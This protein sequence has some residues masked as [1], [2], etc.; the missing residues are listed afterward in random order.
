MK[1]FK[2]LTFLLLVLGMSLSPLA[3]NEVKAATDYTLVLAATKTSVNASD[4]FN[5]T[6]TVE[7]TGTD[8]ISNFEVRVPFIRTIQDTT[9]GGETPSFNKVLAAT[10][11]PENFNSRAWLINT[12]DPKEKATYTLKYNVAASP[13]TPNGLISNVTLPASWKDPNGLDSGKLNSL[14]TFRADVYLN[15]K[16]DQSFEIPLPTLAALN[17]PISLVT[18]NSKYIFSGS[19]TTD[20]KTVTTANIKAFPNFTLESQDIK[21]EWLE[22]IDLSAATVASQLTNLDTNLAT[23]WGKITFNEANLP[24]LNKKVRVTFKNSDFVFA[25]KINVNKDI[26]SLTDA[27]ATFTPGTKIIVLELDK[28]KNLAIAPEIQTEESVIESDQESIE[29]KG[30]VSDPRTNVTYKIGEEEIKT[31]SGI[32]I[33]TGEFSFKV[34]LKEGS[35]DVE[36]STKY[37]NEE[38]TK[39]I[40]VVRR[41]A[42]EAT[43]TPEN[44]QRSTI[45]AP[46]NTI[47]IGLI[48]AALGLIAIIAGIIYYLYRNK[49]KGINAK[50]SDIDPVILNTSAIKGKDDTLE[51]EV[52]LRREAGDEVKDDLSKI[53]QEKN[54]SN[55]DLASMKKKYELRDENKSDLADKKSN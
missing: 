8:K 33:S 1:F 35:Q 38:E 7:N 45:S 27:K 29:V 36:I 43:P 47:T 48:L 10:E 19:K 2:F 11:F 44:T 21:I 17:N 31:L 50:D 40:V 22:P 30:K 46:L 5:F 13:K 51:P 3:G 41:N 6:L 4:A 26:L 39:K 54:K 52:S 49:K 14:K 24:F 28:L 9:Y 23:N 12:F 55:I 15:K 18:F 25:P 20:L 37:R 34:D 32:D 53:T 16:Y 42:S